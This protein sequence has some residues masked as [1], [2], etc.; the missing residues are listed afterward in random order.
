M[1][2]FGI[3]AGMEHHNVSMVKV[4]IQLCNLMVSWTIP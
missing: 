3:G 2:L 1:Y 4:A